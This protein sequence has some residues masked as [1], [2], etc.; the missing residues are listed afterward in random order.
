ME[1]KP[2]W[3]SPQITQYDKDIK[4]GRVAN[5]LSNE[6]V[7]ESLSEL[8]AY[9]STNKEWLKESF[10]ISIQILNAL[11]SKKWKQE[12]LALVLN[13][14]PQIVQKYLSGNCEFGLPLKHKLQNVLGI[15]LGEAYL[16]E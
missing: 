5:P 14:S 3:K 8:L 15:K 7:E 13:V 4:S 9:R 11:E 10:I 2:F 6:K 1:T 16:N 12:D